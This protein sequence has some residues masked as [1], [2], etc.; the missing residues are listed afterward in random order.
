MQTTKQHLSFLASAR[1][2]SPN[3][4]FLGNT[5]PLSLHPLNQDMQCNLY[6]PTKHTIERLLEIL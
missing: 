4:F 6:P 5:V 3:T 2:T 1:A